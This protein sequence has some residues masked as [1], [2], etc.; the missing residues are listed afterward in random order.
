MAGGSFFQFLRNDV[1]SVMS[2]VKKQQGQADD[3]LNAIKGYV[4]K[5]KGSWIGGDADEF[6]ADVARKLVPAMTELILAIAGI[7]V[8]LTKATNTVDSADSKIKGLANQLG[9]IFGKI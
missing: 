3:V 9:D 7:N 2:T 5:V 4:P 1:S 8:N 6:E